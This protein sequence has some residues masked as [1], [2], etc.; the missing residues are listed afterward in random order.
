MR[1][2]DTSKWHFPGPPHIA[3]TKHINFHPGDPD[4]LFIG[5][6][7]GGLQKSVDG[8]KTFT[9][10][11]GMDDDVHRTVINPL[12]ADRMYITGGDGLYVT[13]DGG[14]SWEHW[15]TT[16][17]ELGAYPDLLVLHPRQP[18]LGVRGRCPVRARLLAPDPLRG[19]PHIPQH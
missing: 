12:N 11:P 3:H 16:D 4:T 13:S 15:A 1:S 8:G 6:E 19:K 9:T 14:D 18:D 2:V 5:I 17:H 7:V 10:I